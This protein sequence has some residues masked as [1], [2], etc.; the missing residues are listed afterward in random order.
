MSSIPGQYLKFPFMDRLYRKQ[1]DYY[2]SKVITDIIYNENTNLV[3]LFKDFLIYDDI[4][5]FLKRYELFIT[6]K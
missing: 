5:E 6:T 4:S 1:V 2:N 3:S